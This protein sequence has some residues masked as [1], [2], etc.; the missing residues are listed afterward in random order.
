MPIVA[1]GGG[2]GLSG[3]SVPAAGGVVISTGRMARVLAVDEVSRT[4]RVQPGLINTDL[5]EHTA[6]WHLHFA[7]DP[8][9]QKASTIGGNAA[10]NSGG[11]HCLKYGITT[12][13]ILAVTMVLADG[14]IIDI[15]NTAPDTPGYDLLGVVVG[16]EGTL[17]IV[18]ELTVRL[19]PNPEGV[20]TFLA[21]FDDLDSASDTVSAIIAQG[22]IPAALEMLEGQGI[23]LVEQS[24]HAGYPMHKQ[25][26]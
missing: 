9:S 14:S 15:D 6:P 3:G 13:H 17:G 19:V 4:A 1:R 21:I 10:E 20:K 24:V 22:V 8:S 5:S 18:T 23:A 11:P 25:Y 12:S 16:S 26:C 2:T 7:P